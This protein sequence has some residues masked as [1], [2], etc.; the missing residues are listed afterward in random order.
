MTQE[1]I[2]FQHTPTGFLVGDACFS[3]LAGFWYIRQ[4]LVH[5]GEEISCLQLSGETNP[6]C[7]EKAM[8]VAE[9]KL[10]SGKLGIAWAIVRRAYGDLGIGAVI[11]LLT[12]NICRKSAWIAARSSGHV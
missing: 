1:R 7:E 4:L 8:T 9:V 6:V 11:A 2:V 3:R 5:A 12:F 10:F